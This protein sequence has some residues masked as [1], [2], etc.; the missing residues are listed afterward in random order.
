MPVR[1]LLTGRSD[2]SIVGPGIAVYGRCVGVSLTWS[3]AHRQNQLTNQAHLDLV[4]I[5]DQID[6]LEAV[7]SAAAFL[8]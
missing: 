2:R 1:K 3:R 8:L 5:R 6:T 7:P 4:L